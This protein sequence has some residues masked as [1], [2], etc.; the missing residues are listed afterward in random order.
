MPF[1]RHCKNELGKRKKF[2]SNR[3]NEKYCLETEGCIRAWR[4]DR[5]SGEAKARE[6]KNRKEKT[7]KKRKLMSVD[8]YRAKVLQPVINEIARLID[9][10]HPC[11]ATGNFG[12]M[13]GGHYRSVGANRTTALNLHNIFAQCFES[14]HHKSGDNI[15]FRDGLIATFGADYFEFIDGLAKH[16]PIKFTK[17]DLEAVFSKATKIRN[18]LRDDTRIRTSSERVETRNAVN[19]ELGIYEPEFCA[20]RALK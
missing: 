8:Q 16:P 2:Q 3:F 19:M 12:K 4:D 13:N 17:A 11:I 15:K 18:A 10:G 7:E 20:Y 5:I 6:K 1:C 9:Y 14:N